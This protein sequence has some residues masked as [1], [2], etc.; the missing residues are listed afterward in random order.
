VPVVNARLC[1]GISQSPVRL[2]VPLGILLSLVSRST[3]DGRAV[4][5]W[6][7]SNNWDWEFVRTLRFCVF[8]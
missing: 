1:E 2:V 5:I 8:F 4:Y 3:A 7:Y 6:M